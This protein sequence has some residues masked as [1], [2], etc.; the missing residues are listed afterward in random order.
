MNS[1]KKAL[2]YALTAIG[3]LAVAMFAFY[4]VQNRFA[5]SSNTG[6]EGGEEIVKEEKSEFV[7]TYSPTDGPLEAA[8]KRI[9]F[10][11]VNAKEDGG[12]LGSV[13]VDTIGT[14]ETNFFECV[15]VKIEDNAFFL[16]CQNPTLGSISYNGSWEKTGSGIQTAGKVLWTNQ[17]TP[18]LEQA[19]RLQHS[20]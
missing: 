20:P 16:S 14:E 4:Y 19:R 1:Q 2:T 18:V 17:G 15:D 7:G 5:G 11:T 6:E 8:D 13:K 9:A 10:F 3:I 12:Y